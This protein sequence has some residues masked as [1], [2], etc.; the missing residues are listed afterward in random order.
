MIL[1]FSLDFVF[2]ILAV[3]IFLGVGWATM[4]ASW[5]WSHAIIVGIVLLVLHIL[6]SFGHVVVTGE[7]YGIV[8]IVCALIH[9]VFPPAVIFTTY[10]MTVQSGHSFG[11]NLLFQWLLVFA[12]LG[13]IECL[14]AKGSATNGGLS[15]F[16]LIVFTLLCTIASVVLIG[17]IYTE[18]F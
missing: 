16:R 9:S 15:Y 13:G 11:L 17:L 3:L 12:C 14:W 1:F 8:G 6:I 18:G 4:V 7:D 2:M 10:H 5:L